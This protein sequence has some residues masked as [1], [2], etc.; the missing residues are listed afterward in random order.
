[1]SIP[2]PAGLYRTAVGLPGK[3]QAIPAQ[4]LVWLHPVTEAGK[5]AVALP[6]AVS[7]NRWTFQD[8][9]FLIEDPAW[10]GTLVALPQ[11]GFYVSRKELDLGRDPNG[12]E[13][14]LP[15]GLLLQLS[16]TPN[17]E[18]VIFP[19]VLEPGNRIQFQ[20]RGARLTDL[21]LDAIDRVEFKLLAPPPQ[22]AGSAE[23][24]KDAPV[25]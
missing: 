4:R 18:P 11:Q 6:K 1:M 3:E 20:A 9:G 16:Y 15:P 24:P 12:R 21:Q 17:G 22:A 2:R 5:P 19:G 14:K 23:P 7:D 25:H 8:R 13:I 10:V